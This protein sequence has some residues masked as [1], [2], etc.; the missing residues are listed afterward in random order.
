MLTASEFRRDK[1]LRR[2]A[3]YRQ[4]LSKQLQQAGN[5]ILDNDEEPPYLVAMGKRSD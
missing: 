3:E 1:A 4:I 2:I 5:R